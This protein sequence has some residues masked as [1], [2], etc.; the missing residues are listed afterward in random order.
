MADDKKIAKVLSV[1]DFR[2]VALMG[3]AR[4]KTATIEIGEE[5]VLVG[6]K[7]LSI[8][9]RNEL[10]TQSGVL[11]EGGNRIDASTTFGKAAIYEMVCHPETGESYF[12]SGKGDVDRKL[13]MD[14]IINSPSFSEFF[15]SLAVACGDSLRPSVKGIEEASK[16]SE[17]TPSG[18]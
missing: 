6:I 16:N 13:E 5:A 8:R 2:T 18:S 17:A 4:I 15:E 3:A 14:A 11:K 10:M 9:R 7:S 1:E 12:H